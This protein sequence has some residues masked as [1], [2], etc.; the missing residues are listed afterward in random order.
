MRHVRYH[1]MVFMHRVKRIKKELAR[2]VLP[3]CGIW[4][5]FSCIDRACIP[6][7]AHPDQTT[8]LHNRQCLMGKIHGALEGNL[9]AQRE[10]LFSWTRTGRWACDS[11]TGVFVRRT[12]M[13]FMSWGRSFWQQGLF[14]FNLLSAVGGIGR[15][16]GRWHLCLQGWTMDRLPLQI[17]HGGCGLIKREVEENS[18]GAE[19]GTDGWIVTGLGIRNT[20]SVHR[21]RLN[22]IESNERACLVESV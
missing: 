9:P 15:L 16:M 11:R 3:A 17:V 4:F 21:W 8:F 14:H 13:A 22:A 2:T 12:A 6:P 19:C 10:T 1:E 5:F 7:L 18:R 20:Q